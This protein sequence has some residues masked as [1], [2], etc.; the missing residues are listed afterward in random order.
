MNA[1]EIKV[2][3][4]SDEEW[5]AARTSFSALRWYMKETGLTKL[6]LEDSEYPQLVCQSEMERLQ[7]MEDDETKKSFKLKLTELIQ[8][9]SK[10]PLWF[11]V[12]D[13]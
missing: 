13:Y 8:E 4:M 2:Y 6:D 12:T 1:E 7:F 10:F 5:V 3:A 11:A 9:R